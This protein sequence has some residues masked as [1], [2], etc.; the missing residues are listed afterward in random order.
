MVDTR[1]IAAEVGGGGAV[2]GLYYA[3]Q[4]RQAVTDQTRAAARAL[5][6]A[7]HA[8]VEAE[9]LRHGEAV[10]DGVPYRRIIEQMRYHDLLVIGR[11]PH[12]YYRRPTQ[13]TNTLAE[14][15]KRGT[16]PALVVGDVLGDVQR[17]LVAFD[18]SDAAARTLQRFA[19]FRLF[20]TDLAVEVVYVRSGGARRE[21]D[22]GEVLLR[23]AAAFLTAH[24]YDH[25]ATTSLDGGTPGERLPAYA[26]QTGAG[27]IVA[28]AHS[29]NAMRRLAFGS[30]THALLEGC[31]VPL[32]LHH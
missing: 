19:Q 15:V 6:R 20:G 25:L 17:V 16:A 4:A 14:V 11:V 31:N 22:V 1:Q 30:T 28:G 12:F 13:R 2:G 23:R 10:E 9:H 8:V 18:G 24:G 32:F 21:R 27:L 5:V 26:C 29:V 3:E 7:F